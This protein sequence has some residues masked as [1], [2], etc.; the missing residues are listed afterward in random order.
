MASRGQWIAVGVIIA[1]LGGALIAGMALSPELRPVRPGSEA[2]SFEAVDVATGARVS[3]SDY[4]GDIVLLNLWA[5]WCPPC[6]R[7]MPSMQRL[8]EQLGPSGLKV[9]AVSV[10]ASESEDVLAWA[11]ERG[12][13][14]DVLHHREGRLERLYQTTGL[15]E[16]FVID[17][18]G[19]IVKKEIGA[20]QW[21]SQSQVAFFARLL[22]QE[23][24]A[25][26]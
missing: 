3:L 5:T 1:V 22:E 9:V 26:E 4:E 25:P 21:D 8:H 18:D 13:T 14:F 19:V 15:P 7:E 23:G 10:D 11:Q 24:T 17:R 2:P 20:R 6:E 16:S 12:L